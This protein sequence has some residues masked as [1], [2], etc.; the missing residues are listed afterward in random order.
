MKR[1]LL[2]IAG[3]LCV[4]VLSATAY[5]FYF[6]INQAKAAFW[7]PAISEF[8]EQDADAPPP[9]GSIIFIGSS[10]I[11]FWKSLEEDFAPLPVLNRGFGGSNLSHVTHFAPRVVMPHEPAAVI[12]YAG[13]N[14]FGGWEPKSADQVF[15]DFK[16]MMA[17]FEEELGQTRIY[18]L[19][20]KP[21]R[22]RWESWPKIAK[23][24]ALIAE[25]AQKNDQLAYIDVA[26]GMIGED[27]EPRSELFWYDGLHLSELGYA[28]WTAILR[29]ILLKEFGSL[30]Q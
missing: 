25:F 12:V 4:L 5:F 21:S 11:R 24:N 3:T 28:E 26:S 9:E 14:D 19:S 18:Y 16:A 7:E 10:S 13:D 22:L 17:L 8:E 2:G 1:V 23:A 15:S 20:I 6:T 27:G 30:S 29:P